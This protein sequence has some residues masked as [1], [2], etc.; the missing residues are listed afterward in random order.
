MW[1]LE[2]SYTVLFFM[3]AISTD[4]G[5]QIVKFSSS[6]VIMS[7]SACEGKSVQQRAVALVQKEQAQK[8]IIYLANLSYLGNHKVF[9]GIGIKLLLET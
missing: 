1:S 6:V 2:Y 8:R 9:V 5:N 7:N 4:I 3:K